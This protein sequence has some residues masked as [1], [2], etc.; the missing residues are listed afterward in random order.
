[1]AQSDLLVIKKKG[2]TVRSFYPGMEIHFTTKLRYYEAEITSIRKDSIYMVQYDIKRIPLTNGGIFTDTVGTYRF[3]VNY[4]DIISFENDRK[5]FDWSAS[6]AGLFGGG[7]VL[8]TAGLITWILAK[9]NSRYYARPEV[10]IAGVAF[11]AVGYILMKTG[12]RKTEIGKK[13]TLH[14]I[15]LN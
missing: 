7:V 8:T 11:A 6:G 1:M 12:S 15:S 10:V 2:K 3:G 14:Y 5:G 4:K 13:Y 9:P